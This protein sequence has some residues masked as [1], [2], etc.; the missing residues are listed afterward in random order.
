[1]VDLD[2]L[3]RTIREYP[4]LTDKRHL[5]MVAETVGGD[6]DDA[7]RV[8]DLVLAAEAIAPSFIARSP[9]VAGI[10]GVV[11]TLNDIAASGGEPIAILNTVVGSASSDEELL[12]GIDAAARLYDVPVV[13]GHTTIDDAATAALSVFAI[14]R[15]HGSVSMANAIPGDALGLA[16]C[17][18]GELVT[19]AEGDAFFSHLRGSRRD[20]AATDLR[21]LSAA[22]AAGELR[23]ARDISM[24]G[25]AGSLIQM[26]DGAGLG[27]NLKLD[28]V[29]LPE[30]VPLSDWL[31][32]FQSYGFLLIGDTDALRGRFESAGVA[33]AVIGTLDATGV[34]RMS[35]ED[36]TRDL[37]DLSGEPLTGLGPG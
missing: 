29:P 12:A 11:A 26:L 5:R 9:R 17:T 28:D 34:V 30:R 6:G 24:P 19:G 4:G 23:A 31:I 10:A 7:A 32:A 18:D 36:Q 14:G 22:A 3:I 27:A 1:M 13:G 15:A 20:R 37:W 8:N 21:L 25:L 35:F 2:S 16:V 33:F